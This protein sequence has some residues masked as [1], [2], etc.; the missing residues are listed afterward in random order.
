LPFIVWKDSYRTHIQ[1]I[2][3]DHAHLLVVANYLYEAVLRG[4]G[5]QVIRSALSDLCS[6]AET[7]FATEEALLASCS[8]PNLSSQR[9]EHLGFL[10]RVHALA[11]NSSYVRADDLFDTLRK[12][13]LRHFLTNDRAYIPCVKAHLGLQP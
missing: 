2:D 12:W 1:E 7:H 9:E 8:Y 6:Y 3:A 10:A 4:S 13:L 5:E 11:A